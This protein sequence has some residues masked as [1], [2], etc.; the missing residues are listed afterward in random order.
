MNIPNLPTDNLYKFMALSGLFILILSVVYPLYRENELTQRLLAL[1]GEIEVLNVDIIF[2]TELAKNTKRHS[3]SLSDPDIPQILRFK[4][5]SVK[6]ETQRKQLLFLSSEIEKYK[7]FRWIGVFCGMAL[8]LSGF[9]LWYYRVQRFQDIL[10][11]REATKTDE[12]SQKN[13]KL[14]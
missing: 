9:M 3:F 2:Q 11:Y 7:R 8:I 14:T 4:E 13:R 1:E 6:I 12:E 5:A 10:L